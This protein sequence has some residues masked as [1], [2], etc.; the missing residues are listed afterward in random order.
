ML[1]AGFYHRIVEAYFDFFGRERVY[2]GLFEDIRDDEQ[3]AL[4]ALCA[5]LGVREAA[6][7]RNFRRYNRGPSNAEFVVRSW[8]ASV[9]RDWGG[10]GH[11]RKKFATA[12]RRKCSVPIPFPMTIAAPSLLSMP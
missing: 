9:C 6:Y 8:L 3:A 7:D 12:C 2:V 10:F 4:A 5:F 11:S 1:N